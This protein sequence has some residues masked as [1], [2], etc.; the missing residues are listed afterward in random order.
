LD[1]VVLFV[2]IVATIVA[3]LVTDLVVISKARIP[4]VSDVTLPG[5]HDPKD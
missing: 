4:Y 2:T 1:L 5:E 3:G